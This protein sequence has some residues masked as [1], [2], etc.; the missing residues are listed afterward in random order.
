ME[1]AIARIAAGSLVAFA[2][3][4]APLLSAPG[5]GASTV[6]IEH[7][8][9]IYQ[10]NHSFNDLLGWL[11]EG[12]R[13]EG[14]TKGVLATGE[15]IDLA[16]GPDIVPNV[17]H[18]THAQTVAVDGG[19]MDGFSKISGCTEQTSYA[20]YIQYRPESIPS[21]A[22]LAKGFAISDH[23]FELDT[24]PSWGAHI[25]LVAGQ[26]D[27]FTGDNP[28]PV[29]GNPA[30]PGWGCD[31]YRDA[32]WRSSPDAGLE[33]VPSCVPAQ[34]GTGPYRPSPVQWMPTIMDRMDA[35]GLG[36]R[37]YSTG[38]AEGTGPL[39]YGWAICPTF[40]ECLNGPQAANVAPSEQVIEDAKSGSLANLSIVVPNGRNSQHNG[41]SMLEGDNWIASVVDAVMQGAD[42]DSTA[43][44][45]AYDD[46]GCFYDEVAPPDGLGIRVPMVIVSPY[47]KPGFT[48]TNVASFAS[49]LAYT[50]HVFD[51]EPL[52][53]SDA[54]AYDFSNAFDYTQPPT[55]PVALTRHPLPKWEVAWLDTHPPPDDDT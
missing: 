7:V 45:I 1:R 30:A 21:L 14:T 3:T 43:V 6:P 35:A 11:C 23:T 42:W 55:P 39:P 24:V 47:A 22:L 53:T 51:L 27:G 33:A 37:I 13:C 50:E 12:G 25:E 28:H 38:P 44:F 15:S 41:W 8:V 36:W 2:A 34:D 40:A 31:S 32:W 20:C 52:A 48:D 4:A 54:N 29:E 46:C 49:L 10:E 19:K 17:G 18:S 26:L 5:A 16:Q 9:V